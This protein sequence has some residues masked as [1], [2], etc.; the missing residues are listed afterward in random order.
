L[1]Y[2]LGVGRKVRWAYGFDDVT[3]ATGTT[4][5]DPEDVDTGVR[6]GPFD[7]KIPVL[8]SSMDAATDVRVVG[9]LGKL[10][11]LGVLNIEGLYTR[12]ED[13]LD[14]LQS[15]TKASTRAE[16]VAT[17]QKVYS[18]PVQESLVAR[19][20]EEMNRTGTPFAVASLPATAPKWAPICKEAGCDL[21]VVQSTVTT[22][23]FVSSKREAVDLAKF[24]QNAGIPVIIGNCSNYE[25]ALDLMRLG[26]AAILVGIGPGAACTS[27]RVLGIGVPQI[28]ATVDAAAA[29]DA[30]QRETGK[31]VSI[32]TDGGMRRG[33]DVTKAIAAGAD[34]VMLGSPISSAKEAPGRGYNWG[35]ATPNPELPRGDRVKTGTLGYLKEILFGPTSLN[36]GTMNL[37]GALR[38]A[39]S[40]CGARTIADMQKAELVLAP[41]VL[42]EGKA[43]QFA[44]GGG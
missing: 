29:R 16:A 35:M 36:D 23:N 28:T 38:L 14:P 10:G 1:E 5:I 18:Q 25:G 39:M 19:R 13:P 27:R 17:L 40:N 44:Q 24:C 3:I 9:E 30:Y 26:A 8:S 37:I 11:G 22:S 4:I 33:G 2:E 15:I 41:S 21:F 42:T 34:A 43:L 6:I 32:I 7:L 31:Y 20:V 12:Y